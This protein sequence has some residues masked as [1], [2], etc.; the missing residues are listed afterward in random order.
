MEFE[1]EVAPY[2]KLR[3][4]NEM[5]IVDAQPASMLPAGELAFSCDKNP[6][7]HT[8]YRFYLPRHDFSPETYFQAI[9]NMLTPQDI[10]RNGVQVSHD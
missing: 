4:T 8:M 2:Q 3:T 1:I 9:K 5:I 7:R 6:V 10:M